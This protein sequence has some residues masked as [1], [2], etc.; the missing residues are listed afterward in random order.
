MPSPV[1]ETNNNIDNNTNNNNS[2][3]NNGNQKTTAYAM[4]QP[5]CDTAVSSCPCSLIMPAQD[6]QARRASYSAR[7]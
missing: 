1:I 5:A 7:P 3:N 2:D 4:L 6:F